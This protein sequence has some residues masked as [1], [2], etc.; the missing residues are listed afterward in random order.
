MQR[1][2]WIAKQVTIDGL[3]HLMKILLSVQSVVRAFESFQLRVLSMS[4]NTW[5]K[6]PRRRDVFIGSQ[7][8][9]TGSMW[10]LILVY[11]NRVHMVANP[12]C[13]L[14]YI[15]KQ[16]KPNL[17]KLLWG[18]FLVRLFEAKRHTLNLGHVFWWQPTGKD[19]EEGS[20]AFLSSLFFTLD[21]KFIYPVAEKSHHR[22]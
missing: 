14:D 19:T 7:F 12:G 11:G 10:L 4:C 2:C 15:W 17:L 16:L 6:P 18:I 13:Q 5:Q 3:G 22:D 1:G 9:V 21:N 8:M 20:F